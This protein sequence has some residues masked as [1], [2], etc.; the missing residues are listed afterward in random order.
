VTA[1]PSCDGAARPRTRDPPLPT[2]GRLSVAATP[3]RAGGVDRRNVA[4]CVTEVIGPAL[5]SARTA[6]CRR[7][8]KIFGV[9]RPATADGGEPRQ[10]DGSRQEPNFVICITIVTESGAPKGIGSPESPAR[11]APRTA[12]LTRHHSAASY[13]FA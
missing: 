11:L 12:T 13:P 10:K 3:A 7:A 4:R 1:S 5:K 8:G 6:P 9:D 2:D